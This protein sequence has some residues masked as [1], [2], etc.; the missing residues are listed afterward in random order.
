MNQINIGR[1]ATSDI[2][3]PAQYKTVSGNHVTISKSG[4]SFLL[5]DHSTNG[6]F[7]NGTQVQNASCHVAMSDTI[8]LG[9]AYT[10]NMAEVARLLNA[11]DS[12]TV[13]ERDNIIDVH[14]Q[15]APYAQR[16]AQPNIYVNVQQE[17][18]QQQ[19][20]PQQAYQP[21]YQQQARPQ[22]PVLPNCLD[23]WSWGGFS[24]GWIYGAFNGIY[25]PLIVLIPFLGWMA[26]PIINIV[27]GVKAHRQ[28]WDKFA[29]KG[30]EAG[31]AIFDSKQQT[32]DRVG[33]ILFIIN[34]VLGVLY[35]IIYIILIAVGVA[36]DNSYYY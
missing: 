15:E 16:Q 36:A 30:T 8:M 14:A 29:A 13:I 31:A 4:N 26:A 12:G 6:T 17:Q 34:I 19:H 20:Q 22:N 3:V 7:V 25:W 9:H 33:L 18:R 27:L 23:K 24:L 21:S 10:L 35:L 11:A 2:V 28:A 5:E 1:N 32:W